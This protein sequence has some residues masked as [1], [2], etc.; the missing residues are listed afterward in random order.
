MAASP[1]SASVAR[2]AVGIAVL[3]D[4]HLL[5]VLV[6]QRADALGQVGPGVVVD[7]HRRA[8]PGVLGSGGHRLLPASRAM[9]RA[10]PSRQAGR[11][12]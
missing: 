1:W 3:D 5:D 9:R 2:A 11:A 10:S 4:H 7:D 12:G 6:H 8:A